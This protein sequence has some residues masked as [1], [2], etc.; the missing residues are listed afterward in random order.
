MPNIALLTCQRLPHLFETDQTLI[1]LFK[2][3]GIHAEAAIWD[4]PAIDWKKYDALVIRN[5]WDY[6]TKSDAFINWLKYIRDN[7]ITMLNSAEVVLQN[8]HKFYLRDFEKEGIRIIPTIFSDR[9]EPTSLD[10]LKQKQWNTVVIKPAISAGSYQTK[11]YN[12]NELSQQSLGELL[13]DN[14]WLIQPFLPEIEQGELSMIYINGKFSHAAVKKPKD[15]DFRVQRQYGGKYQLIDPDASL[16]AVA[17]KVIAQVPQQLLYARVDGVMINN[18]F[19][20]MELELIEP[21]LY[22]EL[23]ETI[24]TRFISAI[25][26]RLKEK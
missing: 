12:V 10:A 6:Y 25:E 3:R 26:E 4:D 7:K 8:V 11:T 5:T 13:S 24:K 19:H 21:D 9:R 1:P 17:G 15:G 2:Q 22:F 18:E 20:L 14:D 16:L 23:D